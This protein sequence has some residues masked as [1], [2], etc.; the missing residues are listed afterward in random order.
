MNDVP[1]PPHIWVNTPTA[2]ELLVATLHAEPR[3]AVD[4][5]SNSLHAYRE[6]VCLIQFSTPKT[7]YILDPLALDD[8]S[9]LASIFADASIEKIFHAAEYDVICLQRD[10]GFIFRNIFDTMIA[11]RILGY[12]ATGLGNILAEKFGLEVDKHFQKADWAKRPLPQNYIDYARLDTHYLIALRDIM[13]NELK[14]MERRDIAAEDFARVCHP[15]G[16]NGKASRECWSRISGYQD[17]NPREL[18]ILNELC[19]FRE[20]TAERLNR[21]VFKVVSDQL[22]LALAQS[23][24]SS[25]EELVSTNLLTSTQVERFGDQILKAIRRGK[26]APPIKRT[27]PGRLP[28]SVLIRLD[29]LKKWRKAQAEE[30]KVESDIILPKYFLHAI[31]EEGP[32]DMNALA[33]IMKES[34]WRLE[35]FG[36]EILKT[37]GVKEN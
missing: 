33:I 30:I 6:Q 1:L 14:A 28:D 8:L 9:P 12:P 27:K 32:H 31:A 3:L 19:L 15:N 17:L 35:H 11:A 16:S 7:D 24:P 2:L 29:K 26:E 34:P 13:D 21:P 18:A 10:F 4:T 25:F 20:R 36:K 5:E 23:A 37:L 22:L